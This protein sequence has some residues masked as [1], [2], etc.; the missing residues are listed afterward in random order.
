[1]KRNNTKGDKTT[2]SSKNSSKES[3]KYSSQGKGILKSRHEAGTKRRHKKK[4]TFDENNIASTYHPFDKD[5]GHDKISEPPTPFNRSPDRGR[6]SSPIDAALLSQRLN[7]LTPRD[8]RSN[9]T[10]SERNFH[11]KVK[12]HYKNMGGQAFDRD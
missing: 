3:S 11:R 2:S 12:E 8:G 4:A 5:Y 9:E 10:D 7:Q 1:M 6:Y